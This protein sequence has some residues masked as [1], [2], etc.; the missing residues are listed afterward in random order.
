MP[1]WYNKNIKI[2]D[3]VVIER[4]SRDERE[5]RKTSNAGYG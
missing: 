5:N 2:N 4:E 1:R 3:E